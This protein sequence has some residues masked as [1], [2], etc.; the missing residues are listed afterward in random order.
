MTDGISL[1]L[2]LCETGSESKEL[3]KG[4]WRVQ[5]DWV[6]GGGLRQVGW[7]GCYLPDESAKDRQAHTYAVKG[8][9][10]CAPL[11]A[12]LITVHRQD[13]SPLLDNH[14]CC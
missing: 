5:G 4:C 9:V 11:A 2:F 14:Y 1:G 13:W 7:S 3:G 6:A 8:K 10:D 12:V